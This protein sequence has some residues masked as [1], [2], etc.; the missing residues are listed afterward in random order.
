MPAALSFAALFLAIFLVQLGSGT[1]GP[2][3][4]LSGAA[5]GFSRGEIG[6]LGSAHFAGFFAGCW[7]MPRLIGG[8]GHARGFAVAAAAG[9]IGA[10]LHPVIESAPAWAGLRLLTGVSIAGAYTVV[11]SWMQ[12][13]LANR[14]RGRVFGAYRAVELAGQVV[15]QGLVGLLE[16]ASYAA[17][18]I[19][20]AFCC[21]CLLP[22]ALTRQTPPTT[23][24]AP[25]LRPL[26]ALR[27]A[28]TA[29]A[30]IVTAGMTSA[31]YRMVGPLY[32]IETGLD[33]GEIALL[34]M[35]VVIGAAAAQIPVGW[36]A[37]KTDR[38]HVLIGLSLATVAC[39]GWMALGLAPGDVRGA[40][41]GAF[42]FGATAW[43]VF[44][45]AAAHANDHAPPGFA[46]EINAAIMLFFSL[47]AVASPLVAAALIG[48]FGPGA[49]FLFVAAAHLALI[50]ITLYRMTRRRG[51]RPVTPYRYMPRTSLLLARLAGRGG[52]DGR[53]R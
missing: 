44:S 7:L 40:L 1:L 27:V 34:L 2:L 31:A 32:G 38:R 16:P 13:R 11:E 21:V 4:A 30:A 10:L 9:A 29:A 14:E 3:D 51:I 28:P 50:A 39:A 23:P 24:E 5:L 47:G 15:S 37:D 45:V 43:P 48:L 26:A 6:L 42:L 18:N 19:V 20:A 49:L 25:R 8:V 52:P 41:I 12:A 46:V 22:L 33:Q 17:Y 36:V 35:M 53:D